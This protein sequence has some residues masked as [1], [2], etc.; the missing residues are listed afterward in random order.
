MPDSG[1]QPGTIERELA[2]EAAMTALGRELALFVARGDCICLSG[3]L[4]AGKTVLARAVLRALAGGQEL[5]EVPSPTFALVQIYEPL[6]IPAAHYDLYRLEHFD[7]VEETG[8]YDHLDDYLS[9]VEWPERLAGQLP[10]NRLEIDIRHAGDDA[11]G[12]GRIA[13]LSASGRWCAVLARMQAC[14]GFLAASGWDAARRS[15]LQGDASARRY[16]RLA[17]AGRP[18]AIFMDMPAR[19]DGPPVR[20]GRPYSALAHLAEDVSSVYAINTGLS[21]AGYSAPEIYAMDLEAGLMVIEDMGPDVYAALIARG[22]DMTAPMRC[23]TDALAHIAGRAWP[24]RIALPGGGVHTIA[25]YDHDALMI[26]AELLVDW[27]WPFAFGRQAEADIVAQFRSAWSDVLSLGDTQHPV[28]VLRDYHS[29]NLIWLARR[30]GMARAGMIDTQDC[31][32]GHPAYDLASLVQ[33]ART[34]I[35]P[36]MAAELYRRY[37]N[38]RR[39]H[40]DRFDEEHFG[41]AFAM[42]GAQRS[43][44]ILGI[45]ARLS[46]RDGKH[47]YLVHMPRVSR[48]LETGLAH[49]AL[50]PVK[51]WFDT[52]LPAAIRN[53]AIAKQVAAP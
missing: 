17:L 7:E 5:L 32:R 6:R 46:L 37:C 4:G 50:A 39:H 3:D 14:A 42:L 8:F 35:A 1:N 24:D 20:D 34:D 53:R 25:P 30:S 40:D 45:F 18:P 23:A 28:W 19:P 29:P 41:A 10:E 11:N 21:K 15:F 12:G 27:F 48:Y 13:H 51:N 52:H 43:T 9:L 44:K 36:D 16:E 31:V 33:D 49:P 38:A 26:E 22:T 2:N 47:G